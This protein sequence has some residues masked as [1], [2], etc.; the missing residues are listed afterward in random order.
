M[1]IPLHRLLDQLGLS[2]PSATIQNDELEP[3]AS[4]HMEKCIKLTFA[5][6]K[7]KGHSSILCFSI[8]EIILIYF[9]LKFNMIS[10]DYKDIG[11]RVH[12]MM[13]ASLLAIS[14]L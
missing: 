14:F 6:N 13:R 2:N 10:R 7:R 5:V 8:T 9:I 12:S 11:Y 1:R 3:V 4:Q